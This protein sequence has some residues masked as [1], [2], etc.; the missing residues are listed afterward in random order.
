MR[1]YHM[2]LI[3]CLVKLTLVKQYSY[4]FQGLKNCNNFQNS[5]SVKEYCIMGQ[6]CC[7]VGQKSILVIHDFKFEN[8]AV[9]ILNS[10]NF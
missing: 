5:T 4:F 9:Q 8:L 7:I 1:N 3:F 6:K 2:L 10:H